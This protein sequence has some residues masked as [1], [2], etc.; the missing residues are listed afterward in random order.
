MLASLLGWRGCQVA[1]PSYAEA[2]APHVVVVE[3]LVRGALQE[4]LPLLDQVSAV[5][6][7]QSP[8]NVL[9]HQAHRDTGPVDLR[10][11]VEDGVNE[12]RRQPQGRLVQEDQL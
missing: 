4:D 9:L 2:G 1:G 12:E 5:G 11:D 7:L 6:Q 3:E 8:R 10:D